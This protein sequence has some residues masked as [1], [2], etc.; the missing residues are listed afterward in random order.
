M[1]IVLV[2][3]C[4]SEFHQPWSEPSGTSHPTPFSDA[5][6][7][8]I[9]RNEYEKSLP[10]SPPSFEPSRWRDK[11]GRTKYWD[12]LCITLLLA[13]STCEPTGTKNKVVLLARPSRNTSQRKVVNK[14]IERNVMPNSF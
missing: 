13:L 10:L 14:V 7:P 9:R 6:R 2:S 8:P 3:I 5:N 12:E 1:Y 4:I 11:D